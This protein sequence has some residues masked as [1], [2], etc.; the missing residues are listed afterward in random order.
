[1]EPDFKQVSDVSPRALRREELNQ[2]FVAVVF[3]L[4]GAVVT[5]QIDRFVE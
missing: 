1:M 3:N 5:R 2:K 4:R